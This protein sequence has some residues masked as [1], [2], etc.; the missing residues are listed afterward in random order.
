MPALTFAK[1]PL[2]AIVDVSLLP[3]HRQS[4]VR[5]TLQGLQPESFRMLVDTGAENT[6]VDASKIAAWSLHRATFYTSQSMGSANVVDVYDLSLSIMGSNGQGLFWKLD[7]LRVSERRN[8]P[9]A[10]LPYAGVIGRDVLDKGL[11]VYDGYHAH[12]VLAF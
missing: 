3:S 2:G 9:F 10:G 6:A 5:P 1:S 7:P 8:S 4:K 11:F 12:C